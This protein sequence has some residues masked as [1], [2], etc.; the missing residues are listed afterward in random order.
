MKKRWREYGK[1]KHKK[2]QNKRESAHTHINDNV[3]KAG[4]EEVGNRNRN[5]NSPG[6]FS[7]R[8]LV[9][10]RNLFKIDMFIFVVRGRKTG[11]V[12]D[13]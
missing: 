3:R 10:R 13:P 8:F 7:W 11:R 1:G 4:R 5:R 6:I 12:L 9:F 2:R